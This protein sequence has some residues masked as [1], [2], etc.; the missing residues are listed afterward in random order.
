MITQF[1][2]DSWKDLQN[3]VSDILRQASFTSE[4]EYTL[5]SARGNYEIDVYAQ[6]HID[7]RVYKIIFECKYWKNSIPQNVIL[8]LRSII[9]DTGVEKGYI[10]TTSNFQK[11][12][13]QS[14]ENTNLKLIT[15][16]GFQKEFFKSWYVN[17]F[18]HQMRDTIDSQFSGIHFQFYEDFTVI[19]REDFL[20]LKEKYLELSKILHH[21]PSP[22]FYKYNPQDLENIDSLLPLR[23]KLELEEWEIDTLVTP[24]DILDETHFEELLG[25]LK[26]YCLPINEKINALDLE[27]LDC[28]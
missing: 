10:I 23:D 26:N 12:A 9:E 7:D 18:Y 1:L 14:S 20:Q 21:F 17:Y 22:Y 15:W 5:N 13:Y 2:P 28:D 24:A 3:K 8:G 19:S 11:G 4:V 25:K 27:I 16:E 6:E